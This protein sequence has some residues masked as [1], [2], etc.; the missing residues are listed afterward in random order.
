MGP[1]RQQPAAQS[2]A[3]PTTQPTT[4]AAAEPAEALTQ[5][6]GLLRGQSKQAG[7]GGGG[8]ARRLLRENG[9]A[10][11][12]LV[13]LVRGGGRVRVRVRVRVGVR[14]KVDWLR[15]EW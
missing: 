6:A 5:L 4:Q 2:A 7:V 14:V 12:V 11:V 13:D 9:L 15:G 8:E 1:V 3:Q 10:Q